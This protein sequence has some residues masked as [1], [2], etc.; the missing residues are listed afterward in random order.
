M[1]LTAASYA[2]LLELDWSPAFM[3]Q[4]EDRC[5]RV[6]QNSRSSV[7]IQYFVFWDT[8][9]KWIARQLVSKNENIDRA[10]QYFVFW[11][12]IDEW[13]ARQLV[14]KNENIDR[15]FSSAAEEDGEVLDYF[16]F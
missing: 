11:D 7:L 9:D 2:I 15:A 16:C 12:T 8:I 3:T 5:H 1:T 6:G 13:I 14:S 4:A 10:L